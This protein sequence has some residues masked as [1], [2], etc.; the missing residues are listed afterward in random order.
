MVH[1]S[2]SS[3]WFIYPATSVIVALNPDTAEQRFFLGHTAPV[4]ALQLSREHRL[5]ASAQEGAKIDPP[6]FFCLFGLCPLLASHFAN[7]YTAIL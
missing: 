6:A 2:H 5:V 7:A 3:S 1:W 4:C